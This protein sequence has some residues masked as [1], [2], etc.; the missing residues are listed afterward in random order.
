M[1]GFLIYLL[2][3]GKAFLEFLS[4]LFN[5]KTLFLGGGGEGG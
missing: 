3:K 2:F 4:P 5:C 1:E